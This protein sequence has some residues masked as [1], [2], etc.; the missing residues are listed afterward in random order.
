MGKFLLSA[1]CLIACVSTSWATPIT[2]KYESTTDASMVGGSSTVPVSLLFT[3]DSNLANGTGDIATSPTIG[4]YGPWSGTL[5]VGT[6][7][8]SLTG[9]S[10]NVF[11]DA[12]S[13]PPLID[14]Y[15]VRWQGNSSGDFFGS[16]LSFFRILL[17][18]TDHDMFSSINLP[19][20]PSFATKIDFIQ[21]D[22]FLTDNQRFGQSEFPGSTPRSFTLTSV[23]AVPE[24][25]NY[26]MLLAGL[27]LLGWRLRKA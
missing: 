10:I 7:V 16:N 8:V 21:D 17:V 19:N 2:F 20:E 9:G 3:F 11:N 26:A 13:E 18:D 25:E 6:D 14:S 5:M 15:E 1:V 12:G 24:P 27:G 4:S 22:Y 23:S